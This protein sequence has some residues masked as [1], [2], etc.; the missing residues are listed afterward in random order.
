MVALERVS[1]GEATAAEVSEILNRDGAL[2]VE[3]ALTPPMLAA[4]NA[5]LDGFV[6]KIGTGLRNPTHGFY[7]DFYGERR[8]SVSMACLPSRRRSGM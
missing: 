7:V 4:L 8:P 2:V 6:E 3:N 5:D 1:G